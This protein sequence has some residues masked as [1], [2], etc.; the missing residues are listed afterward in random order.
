MKK[1][2]VII[3]GITVAA[4]VTLG[5]VLFL[6]MRSSS[7]QER[8]IQEA[9]EWRSSEVRICPQVISPAVHTGSGARY[10]FNDGCLPPGWVRQN[11]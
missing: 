5:A 3:I 4:V 11:R 7:A 10:T 1:R 2:T 6:G 9:L 8:A